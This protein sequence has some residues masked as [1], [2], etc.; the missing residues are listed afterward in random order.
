LSSGVVPS[1][2]ALP[3]SLARPPPPPPPGR[4]DA[5]AHGRAGS[6]DLLELRGSLLFQVLALINGT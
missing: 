1:S 3:T 5:T 2:K 6:V 4:L